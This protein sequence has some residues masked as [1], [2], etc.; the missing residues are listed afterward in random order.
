M[1]RGRTSFTIPT[2]ASARQILALG[3]F[4]IIGADGTYQSQA[5]GWQALQSTT[6]P[7]VASWIYDSKLA[8]MRAG[9]ANVALNALTVQ[10]TCASAPTAAAG[11]FSLGAVKTRFNRTG[12]DTNYDLLVT[13]LAGVRTMT[14]FTAY[15]ALSGKVKC[16]TAMLDASDYNNMWPVDGGGLGVAESTPGSIIMS[17]SV[18]PIYMVVEGGTAPLLV[19][20]YTEHRVFY[21]LDPSLA[22]MSVVHRPSSFL[23]SSQASALVES[24][25]GFIHGLASTVKDVLPIIEGA[26]EAMS[27]LSLARGYV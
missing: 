22:D 12:Y 25:G 3:R 7:Q 8:G 24:T 17:D 11:T 15:Q 19:T 23:Q 18:L 21:N 13:T 9:S 26:R 14:R 20:V 6:P 10:V 5:I 1:L 4:S 16:S 27:T 2:N